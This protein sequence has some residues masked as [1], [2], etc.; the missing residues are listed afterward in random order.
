MMTMTGPRMIDE[1]VYVSN[2]QTRTKLVDGFMDKQEARDQPESRFFGGRYD[3]SANTRL[4]FHQY[5]VCNGHNACK[6][7]DLLCT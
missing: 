6:D 1:L 4:L 2:R 5:E 3:T 7:E